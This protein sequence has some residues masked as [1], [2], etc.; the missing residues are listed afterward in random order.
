[1]GACPSGQHCCDYDDYYSKDLVNKNYF[2]KSIVTNDYITKSLCD[3]QK[4]TI[5]ENC[6]K[7]D[8]VQIG[9]NQEEKVTKLTADIKQLKTDLENEKNRQTTCAKNLQTAKTSAETFQNKVEQCANQKETVT[10]LTADIQVYKQKI[11]EL[12]AERAKMAKIALQATGYSGQIEKHKT[13]IKDLKHKLQNKETDCT[14]KIIKIKNASTKAQTEAEEKYKKLEEQFQRFRAFEC[15]PKGL[16][17]AKGQWDGSGGTT[18]DKCMERA[19]T[20]GV[21]YFAWTPRIYRGYCKVLKKG[22]SKPNLNTNQGYG[23][24]LYERK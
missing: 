23:Y 9:G 8:A 1:M 16:D 5:S 14:T 24:R 7:I 21:K 3:K 12:S 4:Q 19:N 20:A 15:S 11:K 22:I 10:K 18:L 17:L 6:N 13:E 2:P